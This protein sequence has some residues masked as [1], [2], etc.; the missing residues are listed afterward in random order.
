MLIVRIL[1][2]P[3]EPEDC[4]QAVERAC[5]GLEELELG[6]SRL[7]VECPT[8]LVHIWNHGSTIFVVVDVC[9][10][11]GD[12]L[13]EEIRRSLARRIASAV[14]RTRDGRHRN[15]KVVVRNFRPEDVITHRLPAK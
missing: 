14:R 1:N 11:P 2:A 8:D 3:K 7:L 10:A 4:M 9:F 12:G 13:S 15:I 5:L 6:Q